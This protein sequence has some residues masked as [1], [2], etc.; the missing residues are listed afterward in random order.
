[1]VRV[2]LAE[3]RKT[4]GDVVDR[5]RYKGERVVLTANGKPAAAVVPIEILQLL[6]D[7]ENADDV[8]AV[9]RALKEHK[10][11]GGATD[12]AQ[13]LAERGL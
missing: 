2:A 11:K 13:F 3:A 10:A 1:V 4:L 12:L 8:R 5:V 7:L 6:Q 9:R